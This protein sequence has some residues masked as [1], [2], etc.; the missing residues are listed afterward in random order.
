M[1][2]TTNSS[3]N[4]GGNIDYE[5]NEAR[6]EKEKRETLLER[7]GPGLGNIQVLILQSLCPSTSSSLIK[8]DFQ[9]EFACL[10]DC[11]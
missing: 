5:G 7:M 10:P 11:V 3:S 6:N 8:C 2:Q 1:K 4:S 9:I